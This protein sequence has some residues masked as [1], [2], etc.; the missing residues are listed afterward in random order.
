MPYKIA[1]VDDESTILQVVRNILGKAGMSVVPLNSGETLMK[2]IRVQKADLILL[3]YMMPVMDGF[4]TLKKLRELEKE[5]GL[6]PTPVV[7]LTGKDDAEIETRC[8]EAGAMDFLKKPFVP[9]VPTIRVTNCIELVR[10]QENLEGEVEKKD[11]ENKKLSLHV[12]RTIADA[13]DAKD[14]YTNGHSGRVAE[15][16]REIAARFGYSKERQDKVYITGLL[17]DVGKIGVPDAIIQK[18][19]KLTE[20]EYA[21]IKTHPE[22]GARIL[23][24]ISEMPE[25]V[26][27][28][29]WHHERYDGMGYPDRLA[30]ENIPEEARI[31][32]V[33]D[34][35]DAMSSKRSYRDPIPQDKIR[36]EIVNGCGTQFDPKFAKIMLSMIDEDREYTM[37]EV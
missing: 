8:L 35:Y 1:V 19:G 18:P 26:T 33:A 22:Q 4:E 11:R 16:A 34:A 25:L 23:G 24:N 17:H 6:K 28:A 10:L 5:L 9:K 7:F 13:L 14:P 15:Y 37:R 20:K 2:F 36:Q 29:R 27:G 30:G 31:I 12:I 21:V 3:D 32:A